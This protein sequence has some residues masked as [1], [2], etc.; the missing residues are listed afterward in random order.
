MS[1]IFVVERKLLVDNVK[2]DHI[3][4]C[5]NPLVW[6]HNPAIWIERLTMPVDPFLLTVYGSEWYE[7]HKGWSYDAWYYKNWLRVSNLLHIY[8]E[9]WCNFQIYET[10]FLWSWIY[11]LINLKNWYSF[12]RKFWHD[13]V[14]LTSPFRKISLLITK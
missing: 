7:K 5:L 6:K 14:K 2:I 9:M 8:F 4:N 10:E 1:Q 12:D 11:G 3:R 13:E